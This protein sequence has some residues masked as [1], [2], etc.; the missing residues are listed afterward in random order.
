MKKLLIL[1]SL[2][3][4]TACSEP[5]DTVSESMP[6]GE[7]KQEKE[8]MKNTVHVYSL[9]QNSEGTIIHW[10]DRDKWLIVPASVVVEHPKALIETSNGQLLEG[11]ITYINKE[12][13][14][15]IVHFRNSAILKE[16]LSNLQ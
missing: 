3:V 6:K 12:T 13:N 15:A 14:T 16:N 8:M 5:M 11:T 9:T 7:I 4:L 1:A 2:L 10:K